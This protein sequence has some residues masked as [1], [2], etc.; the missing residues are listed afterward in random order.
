M[1]WVSMDKRALRERVWQ[2]LEARN[3]ATFPKP[4]R[5]R[6]PNFV[7]SRTAATLLRSLPTYAQARTIFVNPDAA[8]LAVRELALRD[9]KRLIMATPRLRE[10]FILLDPA[11]IKDARGAASIRGAFT[12]G[13]KTSVHGVKV[14]MIVE[15]SVVV[16]RRGG[17]VG[18][19]G[20]FGD[21][22]FAILRETGAITD[23]TPIVTTVHSLQIVDEV[24][25]SE[26]DVPVDFIVTPDR[27]I[28]TTHAHPKPSGIIWKLLPSDVFKRMPILAELRRK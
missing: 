19:G 3:I 20:G 11:E 2:E 5:G 18:K 25:M 8:Q 14:E 10:G 16:D 24:P 28:E 21:L 1:L 26:H 15:G 6:I 23:K 13:R 7:G 12:H 27:I 4:A 22:E 17:R 9:G